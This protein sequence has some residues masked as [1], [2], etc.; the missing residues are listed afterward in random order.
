MEDPGLE[1]QQTPEI[2]SSP[3]RPAGIL[4]TIQPRILIVPGFFPG[5][6][7]AGAQN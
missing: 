5:G 2:F 3:K 6:K 1:S 4:R 7:R